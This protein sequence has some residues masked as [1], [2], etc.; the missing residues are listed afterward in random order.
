MSS[1]VFIDSGP[2]RVN[3]SSVRDGAHLV[4]LSV[5]ALDSARARVVASAGALQFEPLFSTG[6]S[7]ALEMGG[8]GYLHAS[9]RL[10]DVAGLLEVA[11]ENMSSLAASLNLGANV[12]EGAEATASL[13]FAQVIGTQHANLGFADRA[14]AGMT[15]LGEYLSPL[16]SQADWS[17]RA[18]TAAVRGFSDRSNYRVSVATQFAALAAKR[19]RLERGADTP[20]ERSAAILTQVYPAVEKL[21]GTHKGDLVMHRSDSPDPALVW[22]RESYKVGLE[23]FSLRRDA[24]LSAN[25]QPLLDP[26]LTATVL[27]VGVLGG[28]SVQAPRSSVATPHRASDLVERVREMRMNPTAAGAKG[29]D[30]SHG[31]FEILRHDNGGARPSWSVIVRGTQQWLP[32]TPNPKDLQA[33]LQ[34]L[35]AVPADE[36][37]AIMAALELEG[38][39]PGDVVEL[40]GHSQGGMV[41]GAMAANPVFNSRFQVASVVAAGSPIS[42]MPIP[43]ST[44]VLSYENADDFVAALDGARQQTSPSN[45]AVYS[46]GRAAEAHSLTQYALDAKAAESMGNKDLQAWNE[47][48]ERALGLSA[49]SETTGQRYAFTRR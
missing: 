33:N 22:S 25:V 12:Y 13:N 40:A 29:D 39:Q 2:V 30:S 18:L 43:S 21:T 8:A 1:A 20:L 5:G 38:A 15:M 26:P 17:V 4:S 41:A 10:A 24:K 9:S 23:G 32:G 35:A 37:S 42:T 44:L 3:V 36:Q 49:G 28:A 47:R 46:S 11:R 27:P 14:Q 6:F 31:E 16:I 34:L 45:I 19:W 48:R 7:G